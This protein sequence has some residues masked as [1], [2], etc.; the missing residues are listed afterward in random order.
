[1]K[2]RKDL[3]VVSNL[4]SGLAYVTSFFA[5]ELIPPTHPVRVVNKV[6]YQINIDP[7]ISKYQ[8]GVILVVFI[9][10]FHSRCRVL[11]IS[12]RQTD[13]TLCKTQPVRPPAK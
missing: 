9:R 10:L 1:M 12:T 13:C 4:Q 2:K 3:K 11:L 5:G 6:I 7:S 8:P